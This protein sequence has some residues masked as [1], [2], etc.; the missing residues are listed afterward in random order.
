MR[1][2]QVGSSY[3][4]ASLRTTA[5][6]LALVLAG[7]AH[8]TSSSMCLKNRAPELADVTACGH[9]GSIAYCLGNLPSADNPSSTLLSHLEDCF[10][11]A[12]CT[13]AEASIEAVWTLKRCEYPDELR[14]RAGR[15]GD[16][17]DDDDDGDGEETV[18]KQRPTRTRNRQQKTT[19]TEK[20]KEKPTEK[21]TSEKAKGKT[22]TEEKAKTTDEISS[23]AE[24]AS[25]ETSATPIS[26]PTTV[27]TTR[28]AAT[29]PQKAVVSGRPTQCLTTTMIDISVCPT[30]STGPNSGHKLSCFPTKATSSACSEGLICATGSKGDTTCMY[31]HTTLDGG[32]VFV[33]L[34]F[35][36]AVAASM[37]LMIFFCCRERREQRRH[38][39]AAEAAA[40]AREAK[41]GKG[42]TKAVSVSVTPVPPVPSSG[43]SPA[44]SMDVGRPMLQEEDMSG[45]AHQNYGLPAGYHDPF[46]DQHQIAQHQQQHQ[47]QQQHFV[48]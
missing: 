12:G 25:T 18:T 11:N 35:S 14:A 45:G 32:G 48:Q 24:P 23:T 22:T 20:A 29:S 7:G 44:P 40:I 39:K 3:P 2:P 36:L 46:A 38:A 9:K 42:L 5:A 13:K 16:D 27:A 17:D 6:I 43:S 30:Q 33:A 10:V 8:A 47:Q 31:A 15:G 21:T 1:F 19:E 26:T 4:A 41:K 28:E 37:F 34:F